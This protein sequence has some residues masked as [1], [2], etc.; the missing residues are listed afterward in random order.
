MRDLLIA[1]GEARARV[2]FGECVR[3]KGDQRELEAKVLT[4]LSFSGERAAFLD[5]P[6][7]GR[8][9]NPIDLTSTVRPQIVEREAFQK[10]TW[11]RQVPFDRSQVATP[12]LVMRNRRRSRIIDAV[13]PSSRMWSSLASPCEMERGSLAVI[14]ITRMVTA[15]LAG[16]RRTGRR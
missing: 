11:C 2:P 7:P 3:R 14:S 13:K 9:E 15:W 16:D 10:Q 12:A 4:H 6:L 1:Q 8:E 5:L